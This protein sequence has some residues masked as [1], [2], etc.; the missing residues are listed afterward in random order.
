MSIKAVIFDLYG[1]LIQADKVSWEPYLP[2]VKKIGINE[3]E[4]RYHLLTN[5]YPSLEALFY[6]F[7]MNDS[8][9]LARL[10]SEVAGVI[11]SARF[12]DD[13]ESTLVELKSKGL[14]LG[15]I[16]N[17]S[18]A[19]KYPFFRL[20]LDKYFDLWILSC[21]SGFK[22]PSISILNLMTDTL[23]VDSKKAL[24]IGDSY[25]SDYL[26]AKNAGMNAL[27]LDRDDR[28]DLKDKIIS[29]KDIFAYL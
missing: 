13:T 8:D 19:Y 21:N 22:K 5:D 3:K 23:S 4:F 18:S 12:Y 26:G 16:S 29:L 10:K 1:T 24:M 28:S 7:S 9:L 27:L 17:V 20:G 6:N 2:L 11:D 25:S 14:K 15:L